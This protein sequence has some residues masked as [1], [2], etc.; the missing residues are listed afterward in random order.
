MDDALGGL[1]LIIADRGMNFNRKDGRLMN[2]TSVMMVAALSAACMALPAV[3]APRVPEASGQNYLIAAED[4]SPFHVGAFFR[5]HDR[6][7]TLDHGGTYKFNTDRAGGFVAY[8]ITRWLAIYG[9]A[10]YTWNGFDEIGDRKD[11]STVWG[12]GVWVNIFDTELIDG[13]ALEN[14]F[15]LDANAQFLTGE[16]D[17]YSYDLSYTE[18][19][20]S[21]TASIVN[22]IVGNKTMWP[23]AIGVFFGPC[24]TAWDSDDFET[25]YEDFGFAVG[26]DVYLT[27][28]AI[29]SAAYEVYE[30]GENATGVT[31]GVR[32]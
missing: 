28:R 13:L 25:E 3:A 14:R 29:L 27:R 10:A 26:L 31:V 24:F 9:M 20:G 16:A 5:N 4:P 2:K 8:D 7:V 19:Y 17:V 23:E 21:L 15:R 12:A 32:F 18:F 1:V 11:N 30:K 6:T 22:E